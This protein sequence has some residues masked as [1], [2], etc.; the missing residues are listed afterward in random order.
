MPGRCTILLLWDHFLWNVPLPCARALFQLVPWSHSGWDPDLTFFRVSGLF[1]KLL[2]V[3]IKKRYCVSLQKW[4]RSVS[5]CSVISIWS[6]PDSMQMYH[7]HSLMRMCVCVCAC[8]Y[9]G[10]TPSR[11]CRT[12]FIIAMCLTSLRV[13]GLPS[14]FVAPAS[15]AFRALACSSESAGSRTF[16]T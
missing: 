7:T 13:K 10:W 15:E 12:R 6:T 1:S 11:A 4:V 3:Q 2:V 9:E 5:M 8:V 14:G 16:T